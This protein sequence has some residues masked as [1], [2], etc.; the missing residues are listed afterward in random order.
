VSEARVG[1]TA[2]LGLGILRRRK[3]DLFRGLRKDT[4]LKARLDLEIRG[5]PVRISGPAKT[6]NGNSGWKHPEND[7]GASVARRVGTG[8]VETFA[9]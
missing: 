7:C 9:V 3:T 5:G 8:R 6:E 1:K 4:A 2:T